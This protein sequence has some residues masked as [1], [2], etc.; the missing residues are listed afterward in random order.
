MNGSLINQRL[1]EALTDVIGDGVTVLD[2]KF[3]VVYQ[4]RAVK[5]LFGDKAG[6]LCF[7]AYRNREVPCDYCLV[8]DVLLDGKSRKGM[9]DVRLENGD[10]LIVE[11]SS[12]ALRDHDGNIVGAVEVVRDVTGQVRLQEECRTLRREIVKQAQF[13]NIVTQSPKMKTVFR[14][15]ERVAATASPIA[16]Y[17]ESGTGKELVA[18]AIHANSERREGPFVSVNCAAIPENLMESELFGHVKGAFTGAL[19][20]RVGLIETADKGTLFLD[21]IGEVSPAFQVK[22]LRFLQD[23]EVRRVGD[24][25]TR[26]FNVRVVSATNRDLEES[27]KS[28]AFREDLF[29]RLA[30]IPISLPPLR[31]RCEDIPMLVNHFLQRI[32]DEHRRNVTGISPSALK[33]LLDYSW[34]GN[35]RELEN[36]MAYAVHVSEEGQPLRIE[37]FPPRITGA[38]QPQERPGKIGS[39]DEYTKATILALQSDHTEEQIAQ[40]LGCSRKSIWERRRR[41]QI[42]RPPKK[43]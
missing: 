13:E 39:I 26:R 18:R 20:D 22:L 1:V 2:T 17:G 41:F 21:E 6:Q 36:A 28:G 38:S 8:R 9:Q 31:E 11:Y 27:V 7:A 40:I 35:I 33:A 19:R 43:A 4:N 29:F 37:H 23:G 14:L 5:D 12:A 30:V 16:I 42:P 3:R 34:P 32:C 15:I 25:R 24:S 10:V